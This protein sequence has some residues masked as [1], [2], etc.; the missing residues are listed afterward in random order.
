MPSP[1]SIEEKYV[2]AL[3]CI[4]LGLVV[5][6]YRYH[7][8][9][10]SSSQQLL[11]QQALIDRSQH[12]NE[13]LLKELHHRVKNNLQ[14]VSSLLSLQER[15]MS[16]QEA[17]AAL[18]DGKGRVQSLALLHN[19]IYH[20]GQIAGVELRKYI[21]D[22][23]R[24]ILE[25]HQ[26]SE[27]IESEIYTDIESMILDLDSAIP[28]GLIA[29]EIITSSLKSA[30]DQK[31]EIQIQV[32]LREKDGQLRLVVQDNGVGMQEE[33][34]RQVNVLGYKLIRIFSIKLDGTFRIMNRRG[35]SV[36]CHFKKYRKVTWA[37]EVQLS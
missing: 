18:R 19:N 3:G 31:K 12:E 10:Q 7:R 11:H 15:S 20:T 16:N 8:L 29:N 2:V 37:P 25:A 6:A 17:T 9:K 23:C 5:L 1:R 21:E 33:E 35:T 4:G 22:L 14:V 27:V 36:V 32:S 26:E 24:G 34:F 28:L 13:M 30:R